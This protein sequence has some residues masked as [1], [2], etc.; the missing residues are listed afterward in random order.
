M[1]RTWDRTDT[2]ERRHILAQAR[3]YKRDLEKL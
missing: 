1:Y 2:A 3:R